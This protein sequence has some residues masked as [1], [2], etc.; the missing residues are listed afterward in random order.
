MGLTPDSPGGMTRSD[1]PL[2]GKWPDQAGTRLGRSGG[3]FE[4]DAVA[5]GFELR[6]WLRRLALA[7]ALV[8]T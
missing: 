5:E 2:T 8:L 3:W 6:T 7:L 1:T 4:G